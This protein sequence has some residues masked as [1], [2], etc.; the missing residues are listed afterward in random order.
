[1]TLHLQLM[2]DR[3]PVP[4]VPAIYFVEPTLENID[5]IILDHRAGLYS[6]MHLNFSSA[7]STKLLERL[8]GGVSQANTSV[9]QISR[10]VD[11][12]C[13]FVS[14]SSCMYSLNLKSTYS[15]LATT[16]NDSEIEGKL[17]QISLGI[18]SLIQTSCQTLPVIRAPGNAAAG[19]IAQLV[20][21]RLSTCDFFSSQSTGG[22]S[23][24]SHAQRPLLIIL[25]R[26][27]DLS[28]MVAH[29]WSYESLMQDLLS[30][31]LNKISTGGKTWDI[32]VS[33]VFWQKISHLPFPE[34]ATLVNEQVGEFS[35]MRTTVSDGHISSAMSNLPQM[36]DLKKT[37][38]MHT[39]IATTL[40]NTIKERD[41]DKLYEIETDLTRDGIDKLISNEKIRNIDKIRLIIFAITRKNDLINSAK[42]DSLISTLSSCPEI[43][44]VKYIRSMLGLR[45]LS[46]STP[47]PAARPSIFGDLADKVKSRGEGLLAAGMKNLKTILPLNDKLVFTNI[48]QQL[49]DNTSNTVCDSFGY[50]DPLSQGGPRVRGSFRQIFVCVVGGG[51]I[52]EYENLTEWASKS[53]RPNI[54]YGAT[55]FVT[56]DAFVAELA[57]CHR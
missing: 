55:D 45:N 17:D 38:D 40:L 54:V 9:S 16:V 27:M 37:I 20:S 50:F 36:T 35:R 10:V 56:P 1:M 13:S 22:S 49:A 19:L 24:P 29:G 31:G 39:T 2:T 30:F 28:P 18:V 33:D 52:L 34:A 14:L 4:D 46:S 5:R 48:V 11:R 25:D 6:Y 57:T 41:I 51:S 7:I 8:A 42:L 53:Q 26:D 43:G 15:F 3:H 47:P 32:D 12:Y 23:D 44:A 21:K